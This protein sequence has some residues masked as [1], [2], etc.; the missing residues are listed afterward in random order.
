VIA[1][2]SLFI[3]QAPVLAKDQKAPIP[4]R[5]GD[6]NYDGRVDMSDALLLLQFASGRVAPTWYQLAAGDIEVPRGYRSTRDWS[7]HD[8]EGHITIFDAYLV[9]L[10]YRGEA[11]IRGKCG[12]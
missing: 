10:A 9:I 7:Y 3:F 4:P 2:F 8:N 11:D 5:C 6:V 12:Y 1:L